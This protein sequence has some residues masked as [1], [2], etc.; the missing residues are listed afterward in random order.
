MINKRPYSLWLWEWCCALKGLCL[1]AWCIF[2]KLLFSAYSTLTSIHDKNLWFTSQNYEVIEEFIFSQ[3]F[4]L[5]AKT[6][7]W[8]TIL[9]R[10]CCRPNYIFCLLKDL[11]L[12]LHIIVLPEG[13][14][15]VNE[16]Y[17]VTVDKTCLGWYWPKQAMRVTI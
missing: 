1:L 8:L 6:N 9:Q 3:L 14:H 7:T 13:T 5:P 16:H 2:E 4:F 12:I 15:P 11:T 17:C 10:Q